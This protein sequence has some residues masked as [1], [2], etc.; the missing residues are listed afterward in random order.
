MKTLS[1][2]NSIKE[3]YRSS[4]AIRTD[5]YET[6]I[7]VGMGNSGLVSGARDILKALVQRIEDDGL[8]GRVIVTQEA[9]VSKVGH[10]PV[11]K[12]VENGIKTAVYSNVTK[13][14]ALRIVDEHVKEGRI[15][16]EYLYNEEEA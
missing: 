6:R 3:Q 1:E 7:V 13:E 14:A 4:V 11:V 12:I 8:S 10:N 5:D 15:V 16:K 9:R 2:L